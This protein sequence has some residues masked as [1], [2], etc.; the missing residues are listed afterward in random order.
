M[1]TIVPSD[2]MD[3]PAKE[4]TSE[5]IAERR[6]ECFLL[7]QTIKDCIQQG[8][9][10]MWELMKGL[11]DFNE[12]KGWEVLGYENQGDWL[13]QPEV[14]M[15]RRHFFRLVRTYRDTVIERSIPMERM[16][17]LEP[18]KVEI[19]LPAIEAAVVTVDEGLEDA[20][21]LSVSDL[22]THYI[23]PEAVKAAPKTD[24]AS[25]NGDSP[26]KKKAEEETI[27]EWFVSAQ[28]VD[29]WVEMGGNK[30]KAARN[31]AKFSTTHPVYQAAMVMTAFFNGEEV[32]GEQITKEQV[33]TAWLGITKSLKLKLD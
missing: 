33:Q 22:R 8:R 6:E 4:L 3:H 23:G 5:E 28:A 26:T 13:A 9:A 12:A 24:D 2:E 20:R 21:S 31:W 7:E 29:S 18:S 27:E 17:E 16:A 25:T 10:A 30:R 14:G 15:S 19:V 11:H 1:T 32:N